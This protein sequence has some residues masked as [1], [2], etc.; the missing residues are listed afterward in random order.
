MNRV[1]RTVR[2]MSIAGA[3][4]VYCTSALP[5]GNSPIGIWRTIDDKT[6]KQK[7]LVQISQ[8]ASGELSGVILQ[9]LDANAA[10]NRRCTACTDDRKDQLIQGLIIV[11]SMKR[12]GDHWDS[13]NILDPETG[14]VYKCTMTLN[15]SGQE[16][17]VR[18]YLGFSLL[19]RSQTWLRQQ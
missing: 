2:S 3:V 1:I 6:G 15:A 8:N 5:Q 13:G 4:L 7:A 14:D 10:P 16:L 12:S 18:G 9:D 17:V 19:G 11:R